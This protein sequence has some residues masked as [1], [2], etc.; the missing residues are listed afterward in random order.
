MEHSQILAGQTAIISG[1]LG[2]IGRAVALEL[3]SRGAAVAVGDVLDP[4]D[5]SA[6][7]RIATLLDQVGEHGVLAR[8]DRVD[9][10]DPEAV[11]QWVSHVEED[12]GLPTLVIVNAGVVTFKSIRKLAHADWRRDLSVNIDGSFNL[13]QAC[14]RRLVKVQSPGRIVFLGSWVGRVPQRHIPAYCVSKAA[15][16]MLCKVMALEFA[17]EG[18]LCNEVAPGLVDGGLSALR[19]KA[20][21]S[22]RQ[23][24]RQH[25]PTHELITPGQVAFE[26]AHLCDPRNIHMTGTVSLIDGGLSLQS[27]RNDW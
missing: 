26:V 25:V 4:D 6:G 1:G 9:V 21:P 27:G 15:V 3:A 14:A 16:R 7:E 12:L 5:K 22:L 20:D 11:R 19:F 17:S 23:R 13:S 10:T 18:I 2:D 24:G 8:Y